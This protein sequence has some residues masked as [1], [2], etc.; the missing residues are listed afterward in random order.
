MYREEQDRTLLTVRSKGVSGAGLAILLEN[1]PA[2]FD[3][4]LD[5]IHRGSTGEQNPEDREAMQRSKKAADGLQQI[6]FS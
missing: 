3:M 5:G 1:L 6:G 4:P 2:K